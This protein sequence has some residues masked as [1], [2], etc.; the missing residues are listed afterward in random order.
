MKTKQKR[1][2]NLTSNEL[3]AATREFD[4]PEFNP[5]ARKPSA[6]ERADLRRVQQKAGKDRFRVAIALEQDLIEQADEYA[7][8]HGITFSQLVSDALRQLIK[9]KSA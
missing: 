2:S 3:A 4:D 6:R 7:T 1:W 8:T 9:K 5:P